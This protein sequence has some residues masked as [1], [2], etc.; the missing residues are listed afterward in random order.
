MRSAIIT[1]IPMQGP[2]DKIN[3][4]VVLI[5]CGGSPLQCLSGITDTL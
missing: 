5:L 1:D 3:R 2:P 4:W